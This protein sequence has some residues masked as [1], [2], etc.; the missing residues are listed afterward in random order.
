MAFAVAVE[1][2]LRDRRYIRI[3]GRP[4]LMIYRPGLLPDA[5]TTVARWRQHF[6]ERGIGD[7]Y[8][9]MAQAFGDNDPRRYGLDAVAG[10]PPHKFGWDLPHLTATIELLDP[11]FRG[12]VHSYEAMAERAMTFCGGGRYKVFHGVCPGWDNEPRRPGRGRTFVG[13]T[14]GKYGRWLENACRKAL[15]TPNPDERIVFINAWNEWAEGAYLEPDRHNGY[16]Y[17]RETARV[18]ARL[19]TPTNGGIASDARAGDTDRFAR[20]R[21]PHGLG[22]RVIREARQLGANAVQ[23]I[24]DA[25]RPNS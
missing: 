8:F 19:G 13:S 6:V 11:G 2:A 7:P 23:Y 25:I 15:R 17:L 3:N 21:R 9:V 5:R 1:A 4:L 10:F 12:R 20:A 18:L 24:A 16:A 14:P 22:A